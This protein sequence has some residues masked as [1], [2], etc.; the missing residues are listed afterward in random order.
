MVT[1]QPFAYDEQAGIWHLF[2]Y[3]AVQDFLRHP[4][5]WSTAQRMKHIPAEQ[6]VLRLLTTDPPAHSTLRSHFS[7]A[8]RL[9]RIAS[10][11]EGIRT[12]CRELLRSCAEKRYFDVVADFARPLTASTICAILGVPDKDNEEILG[13]GSV[14]S[15]GPMPAPGEPPALYMGG[16]VYMG[17]SRPEAPI[18]QEY[19][20]GLVE[21]RRRSPQDDLIS[22][23]ARIPAQPAVGVLDL[24]AL[25]I[26]QLG[27]GQNTTSHVLG[28]MFLALHENPEAWKLVRDDRTMVRSAIE[29]SMRYM[30]PLQARPRVSTT[31][32]KLDGVTVPEGCTGLAWIQAANMDPSVFDEPLRYDVGRNPNPHMAFG[33]GE[34]FCL[35]A[36][37]ARLEAKIALEE[38]CA[39]FS[40][41][42]VV[43]PELQWHEDFIMRGL[44][45]LR[46]EVVPR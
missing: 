12:V 25:L 19:L 24:P 33:F 42:T 2:S 44:R 29:E 13:G 40:D 3:D 31:S 16:T 9:K 41:F 1:A 18:A 7:H 34:H 27:A 10:L 11:E 14:N 17:D 22:D 28:S 35:G 30:S 26:E 32:V 37:L 4:Q 39:R 23:L 8:Y 36:P 38:W 6:R 5:E 20:A 46:V 15:L 43:E 45:S 21:E